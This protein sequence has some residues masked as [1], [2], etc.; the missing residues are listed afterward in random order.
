[1]RL[2]GGVFSPYTPIKTNLLFFE[3]GTPTKE[4]WYYEHRMPE[5][6]KAYNKTRPIQVQEFEPIRAW[7]NNRKES[8]ICWKVGMDAIVE[9]GYD[10]D[11]K[12]PTKAEEVH[13]YSS[14][15][16]MELLSVSLQQSNA[17]FEKLKMSI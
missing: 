6:Y 15:E 13:E 12:N 4:I 9:R 8:D 2:P 5:G 10:L 1:M 3:K 17:L 7:W 11:I 16:L 14:A